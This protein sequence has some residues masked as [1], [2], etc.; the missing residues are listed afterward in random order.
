MFHLESE[1]YRLPLRFDS[2]RLAEE[3]LQ[4]SENEWC[5]H[6]QGHAGNTALPLMSV[7]GGINDDVK[8]PMRPT[9]FLARCPYIAQV[10][11]SLGTVIGRARLMRIAGQSD[12]TPH[13]DTNYYWMHHVRVHIPAVTFPEVKFL[14]LEKSVHLA[15]GECWIFDSW[16]Q[17]NVVNP[18]SAARIHLVADTVGSAAFWDLVAR[19]GEDGRFVPFVPS[20][21]SPN[22]DFEDENFP[23]VM[24]PFEQ[25][26]LAARML[27][28]LADPAPARA[29]AHALERLHQQWHALWTA[30]G[31]GEAGWPAYR[32]AIS[33][34]DAALPA[35]AGDLALR[36]GVPLLEALRQA[37]VRPA[38]SPEVLERRNA[39]SSFSSSSSSSPLADDPAP[40]ARSQTPVWER[41]W[42]RNSI[43]QGGGVRGPVP[44]HQ[45]AEHPRPA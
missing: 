31:D 17:H 19:S 27:G 18:V 2:E 3:V 42:E 44:A 10:L 30:H 14:C 6:P 45:P 39:S 43:S 28:S 26:A 38:L 29:L 32:E 5:P 13:V 9:P 33:A 24:H 25:Q 12:A 35:L 34:F 40:S 41:N 20:V 21:A 1:F 4:F 15:A 7:G 37:I 11:A 8:G 23:V 16:K 36:N 22:I